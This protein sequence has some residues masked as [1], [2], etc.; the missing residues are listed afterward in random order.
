MVRSQPGSTAAFEYTEASGLVLTS[1]EQDYGVLWDYATDLDGDG[2]LDLFDTRLEFVR[3]Y[4]GTAAQ[5]YRLKRVVDGMKKRITISYD[6]AG[7]YSTD[8]SCRNAWPEECLRRV[9]GLVTSF[10]VGHEDDSGPMVVGR[11]YENGRINLAGHG[12]LGFDRREERVRA[13]GIVSDTTV[14]FGRPEP[15][16]LGGS[17][18][19]YPKAG[20]PREITT[21]QPLQSS[22]HAP[23]GT[24]TTRVVNHWQLVN[25]AQGRIFTQVHSRRTYVSEEW[26]G[27]PP[28]GVS[29]V[30]ELFQVD[31][32]GNV[33]LYETRLVHGDDQSFETRRTFADYSRNEAEWLM[34]NPLWIRTTAE[35]EGESNP[36][37]QYRQMT[38]DSRGLLQAVLRAPDAPLARRQTTYVRDQYGNA[39]S[40]TTTEATGEAPRAVSFVYDHR[41]SDEAELPPDQLGDRWPRVLLL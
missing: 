3:P 26:E 32:Y 6:E 11:R 21:T 10:R 33:T 39:E 7:G 41:S 13:S 9:T 8:E 27:Q 34:G 38:Y 20:L 40:V 19:F 25:S 15:V 14:E 24:R 18:Y 16:S 31:A 1:P 12:W 2:S 17:H 35:R 37:E 29:R 30:D 5:R 23:A 28:R 4:F 22:M 36:A